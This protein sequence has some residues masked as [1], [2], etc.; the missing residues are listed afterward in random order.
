MSDNVTL[1]IGGR[2]F[3]GWKHVRIVQG[4]DALAGTFS[5]ALS[6]RWPGRPEEWGI[7][8]GDAC[9]LFIGDDQVMSA[10]IDRFSTSLEPDR[11]PVE[12]VGRERTGDLVDCSA[13]HKPGSWKNRTLEQI[14]AELAAPFG[15]KASAAVPTGRAFDRFALQQGETVFDAIER[16][17]RQRGVYPV[18]TVTG[19]LELRRPGQTDGGYALEVGVNLK[20]VSF[21]TD[22]TDRYSQ[23]TLKAN[24]NDGATRPKGEAKDPGVRRHRPLLIVNDDEST[25]GSLADRAKWEASV[26]AG[27]SQSV[28]G[29]V[30]GWR[31]ANGQLY[32]PDRLVPVKAAEVGVEATLLVVSVTFEL[33]ERGRVTELSLAPK[34]AYQLEPISEPKAKRR[35]ATTP[36]GAK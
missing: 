36:P 31:A 15:I 23:Y 17:A 21:D 30:A 16:M 20:G 24:A 4:L 8:A 33:G 5:V 7:E 3:E 26:R 11:H 12:V 25:T 2:R 18:T 34:E 35:T 28:T 27:K 10:W 13:V 1:K 6:E 32:R 22:L 14:V 29:S 9:E 19:D